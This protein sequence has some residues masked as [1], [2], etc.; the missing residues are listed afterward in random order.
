MVWR[1]QSVELKKVSTKHI[2]RST[3]GTPKPPRRR[4]L[5]QERYARR[6]TSSLPDLFKPQLAAANARLEQGS[7]SHPT[8]YNTIHNVSA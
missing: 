1:R 8:H 4:L 3:L 6:R 2:L 5:P 7:Q